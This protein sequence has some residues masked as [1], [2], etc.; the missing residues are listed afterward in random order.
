MQND[1]VEVEVKGVLPTSGGCAV[2]LGNDDKVFVIYIDQMVGAAITMFMRKVPKERPQTHDLVAS[3]LEALGAS[4]DRV[5]INDFR[6]GVF[7]ARLIL[8]AENEL[9]HKKIIELDARPSDSIAIA[10]QQQSPIF[11]TQSVWDESEDMSDVLK[12]VD[13]ETIS[14]DD[15]LGL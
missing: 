6:D 13:Q 12:K 1:V 3:M 9:H 11:V 7:F 10:V 8:S 5:I 14:D 2:F 4:V 15:E